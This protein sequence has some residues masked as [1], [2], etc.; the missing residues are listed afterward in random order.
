MD[1]AARRSY[2]GAP[3]AATGITNRDLL[4]WFSDDEREVCSDC[5]E[6]ACVT[7]PGLR[8]AF[9]L[10]CNAVKVDGKKIALMQDL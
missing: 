6:R 5:G 10:A 9:C 8:A 1:A 2:P 4:A 3:M 7:F